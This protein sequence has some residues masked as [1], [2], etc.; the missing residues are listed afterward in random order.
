MCLSPALQRKVKRIVGSNID[1]DRV[2]DRMLLNRFRSIIGCQTHY[3]QHDRIVSSTSESLSLKL[4]QWHSRAGG[5]RIILQEFSNNRGGTL[6]FLVFTSSLTAASDCKSSKFSS[7]Y[8]LAQKS[9][10]EGEAHER[11]EQ[12]LQS[13][14]LT[15]Q[16]YKQWRLSSKMSIVR[17]AIHKSSGSVI[18]RQHRRS[19]VETEV[20]LVA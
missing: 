8:C 6:V 5:S 10:V 13:Y 17:A 16:P 11:F 2:E 9:F 15:A 7:S 1:I 12:K 18:V 14:G 4:N 19:V 20:R 3:C